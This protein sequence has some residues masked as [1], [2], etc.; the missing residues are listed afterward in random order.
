VKRGIVTSKSNNTK[1]KT[2]THKTYVVKDSEDSPAMNFLLLEIS[3][4]GN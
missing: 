1:I 3:V 2:Q 4:N